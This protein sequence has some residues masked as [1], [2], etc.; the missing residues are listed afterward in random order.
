MRELHFEKD[1]KKYWKSIE[2]RAK[3]V[4]FTKDSKPMTTRQKVSERIQILQWLEDCD[5]ERW[6]AEKR[7]DSIER[8]EGR[9]KANNRFVN[10][11]MR[12]IA[13]EVKRATK[14]KVD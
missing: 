1:A 8:A 6:Q 10:R 2:E 14:S 12:L 4:R 3:K 9:K 11:I 7:I 13:R 5:V